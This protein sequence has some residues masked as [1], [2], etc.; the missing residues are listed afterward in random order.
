MTD[1][2]ATPAP[3]SHDPRVPTGVLEESAASLFEAML[4][5]REGEER[6]DRS[7]LPA[8]YRAIVS[9]TLLLPVPPGTQD[10][11]HRSLA[12]AVTDQED[13]E[14]G[15]MLARDGAGNA[16][17]VVFASGAALAAWSPAGTGSI[18]L[19]GR[20]VMRNLAASGLPAII[21]PA[22]PIPYRFEPDELRALAAGRVPGSDDHLFSDDAAA[23]IRV[24]VPAQD[25][26]ALERELAKILGSHP[27]AEAYL[28][29]SAGSGAWRLTLAVVLGDHASEAT[30][31]A[32]G[33]SVRD[34]NLEVV[35]ADGPMLAQLRGLTQPFHV[36]GGRRRAPR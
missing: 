5:A 16:V 15:V 22:G 9:A 6:G 10:E 21:D 12:S 2:L 33:D 18:A 25:T 7:A 31:A 3:A 20:V 14:I 17:S 35:V 19:P 1:Q 34:R 4:A 30:V 27:I 11:A 23:S 8:F 28:V 13:V 24:R 26:R 29:D 36:A 32:L